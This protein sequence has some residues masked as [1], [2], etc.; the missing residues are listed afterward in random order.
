MADEIRRSPNRL[1]LAF[2]AAALVGVGGLIGIAVAGEEDT[3]HTAAEPLKATGI[4]N[5]EVGRHLFVSQRCS[6]CHSFQGRGGSDAPPL[7]FMKGKLAAKDIANMSGRIWNHVPAMA[8]FYKEED[9]PF[10]AFRGNEMA[11]LIAY[12][13]GGGPPPNVSKARMEHG[14]ER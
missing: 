14:R 5:P 11:D 4:G 7:D 10:P 12:L 3:K 13:H 8:R 2:A 1:V 6:A 9:I